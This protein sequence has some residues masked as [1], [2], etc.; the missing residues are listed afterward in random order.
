MR[1][2]M[3]VVCLEAWAI[4]VRGEGCKK[5]VIEVDEGKDES[6][7]ESGLLVTLTNRAGVLGRSSRSP[8]T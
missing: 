6:K 7:D 5:R 1:V 8:P 3:E 4:P 2:G